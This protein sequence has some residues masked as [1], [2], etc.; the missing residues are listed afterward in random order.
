MAIMAHDVNK[1]WH[2]DAQ[3]KPPKRGARTISIKAQ[4][5][6]LQ[7]VIKAAIREVTGDALFVTAYPSVVTINDYYCDLLERFAG[8][9]HCSKLQE[10]FEKDRQFAVVI[11][12]PVVIYFSGYQVTT[13]IVSAYRWRFAFRTFAAP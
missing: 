4:P 12:R 1:G 7:A 13:L 6:S 11:S 10:R 2:L 8:N 5:E 9:L 3:Y